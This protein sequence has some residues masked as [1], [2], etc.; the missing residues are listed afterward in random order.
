MSGQRTFRFKLSITREEYLSYYSGAAQWV[1]ARAFEGEAVRFPAAFL[2]EFV[3]E[4]G[5]YG[6]FE[7]VVDQRDKLVSLR[8]LGPAG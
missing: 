4:D 7:M 1:V 3:A 5:V 2:R 6:I 8:R